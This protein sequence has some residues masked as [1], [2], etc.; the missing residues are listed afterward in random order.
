MRR[1]FLTVFSFW[2]YGLLVVARADTFPLAD[3]TTLSGSIVKSTDAGLLL[4]TPD[5]VYTNVLWSKLSQDGLKQLSADPKIRLFVEPFIEIPLSER[6]QKPP[7]QIRDVNRLDLPPK[8][9]LLG[10]LASSS[11][12]LLALI[13]IYAAN[14]YSGFEI[15]VFRNRP[16][17]LVMVVAAVLPILGPI[18]F[19]SMPT[20]IEAAPVE[21]P[22]EIEAATFAV[23]G[24]VSPAH[25]EIQVSASSSPASS[26]APSAQVFK[27]GQF[28]FNRRFIETKFA[29]FFSEPR[30]GTDANAILFLKANSGEFIVERIVRIEASNMRVEVA[31][32]GGRQ[33]FVVPFADIQEIQLQ[34]KTA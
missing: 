22:V 19:L 31:V 20:Y 6:P 14:I 1:I 3:G 34:P 26:A 25:E 5:D 33:E 23:P 18:I 8:Q 9:S 21:V 29:A 7:I 24:Q 15:A 28:T 4:H 12:G 11:V 27:R 13:L 10:A 17:G 16:T 2:F 30:S 32:E